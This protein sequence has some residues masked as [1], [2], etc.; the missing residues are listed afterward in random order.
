MRS[1][2]KMV[3]E[4]SLGEK[5]FS[6]KSI[7]NETSLNNGYQ[8]NV[9][10]IHATTETDTREQSKKQLVPSFRKKSVPFLGVR[11]DE[12]NNSNQDNAGFYQA[13]LQG[14]DI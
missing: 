7:H 12:K 8:R 10:T 11:E 14:K 13:M 3:N 1:I 2:K 4:T 9:T 5:S 6:I